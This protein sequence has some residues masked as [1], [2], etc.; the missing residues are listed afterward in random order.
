MSALDV[1]RSIFRPV[2][3]GGALRVLCVGGP[4]S[5]GELSVRLHPDN[6]IGVSSMSVIAA[7]ACDG[8]AV[9][10]LNIVDQRVVDRASGSA[11]RFV[12]LRRR[13]G[14][15]ENAT[16]LYNLDDLAIVQE[17]LAEGGNG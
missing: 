14:L 12:G 1:K 2:A 11:D 5:R 3:A 10:E 15:G 7:R 8:W 9:L 13:D 4:A 6:S 17:F 16:D